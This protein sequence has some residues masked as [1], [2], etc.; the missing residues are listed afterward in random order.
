MKLDLTTIALL[1]AAA[2]LGVLYFVRRSSR[3]KR[4]HRKL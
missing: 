2:F 1:V 3:L 4:A